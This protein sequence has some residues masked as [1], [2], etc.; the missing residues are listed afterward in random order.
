[1]FPDALAF[2]F[3][4]VASLFVSSA[5]VLWGAA[6]VSVSRRTRFIRYAVGLTLL[7]VIISFLCSLRNYGETKVAKDM[8]MQGGGAFGQFFNQFVAVPIFGKASLLMPL[9]ISL[10]GIALIL[11]IAF[12]L[13]PRHFKFVVQTTAWLKSVFKKKEP[14]VKSTNRWIPAVCLR[15]RPIWIWVDFRAVCTWTTIP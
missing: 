9:T 6:L 13:R 8:L 14:I 12:G 11:V 2:V 7:S 1:M 5:L 10:V 4:R 3:G 15:C